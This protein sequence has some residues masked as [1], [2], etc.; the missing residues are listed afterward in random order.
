MATRIHYFGDVAIA[1]RYKATG[2]ALL[3]SLR[4]CQPIPSSLKRS[5]PDGTRIVATRATPEIDTIDIWA[6]G[7]VSKEKWVWTLLY[8]PCPLP[9]PQDWGGWIECSRETLVATNFLSRFALLAWGDSFY[10]DF[11]TDDDLS[12]IKTNP[13]AQ[14]TDG[15]WC[16]IGYGDGV[17]VGAPPLYLGPIWQ[18]IGLSRTSRELFTQSYTYTFPNNLVPPVSVQNTTESGRKHWERAGGAYDVEGYVSIPSNAFGS[19]SHPVCDDSDASPPTPYDP[20][21]TIG[22]VEGYISWESLYMIGFWKWELIAYTPSSYLDENNYIGFYD[23]YTSDY[24]SSTSYLGATFTTYISDMYE[25]LYPGADGYYAGWWTEQMRAEYIASDLGSGDTDNISFP[26]A[27]TPTGWFSGTMNIY[28]PDS[29]D[30]VNS[31]GSI[32]YETH[33]FGKYEGVYFDETIGTAT[34]M[35]NASWVGSWSG[36]NV[37]PWM[38]RIYDKSSLLEGEEGQ[39]QPSDHH[40]MIASWLIGAPA[41][42]VSD[43]LKVPGLDSVGI[44]KTVYWAKHGTDINVRKEYSASH[45]GWHDVYTEDGRTWRAYGDLFA[46]LKKVR[47]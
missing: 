5:F 25:W 39:E 38:G 4:R 3:E 46:A 14:V 47:G 2:E 37:F 6:E 10:G 18:A 1:T 15:G 24:S 42:N 22:H 41:G 21:Y 30:G 45:P 29:S 33:V 31:V 40:L 44:N 19:S 35:G 7:G 32:T 23:K 11:T 12:L 13:D 17:A 28:D 16:C 26:H 27:P 36:D 43:T 34:W 8:A 9:D 20:G